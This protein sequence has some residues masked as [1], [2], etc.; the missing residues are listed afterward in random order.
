MDNT[1]NIKMMTSKP[2]FINI[3]YLTSGIFFNDKIKYGLSK[4]EAHKE[5]NDIDNNK[6]KNTIGSRSSC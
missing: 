1:N 3:S 5:C 4:T 6:T 2:C